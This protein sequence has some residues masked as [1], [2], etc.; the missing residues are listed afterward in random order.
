M[1]AVEFEQLTDSDPTPSF[2]VTDAGAIV[3]INA[4]ARRLVTAPPGTNLTTLVRQPAAEVLAFIQRCSTSRDALPGILH[5]RA[6]NGD[7]EFRCS[8]ASARPAAA[9]EPALIVLR[10]AEGAQANLANNEIGNREEAERHLSL[11]LTAARM[12]TWIWERSAD[13]LTLSE[14]AAE[15]FGVVNSPELGWGAVE[16]TI[17]RVQSRRIRAAVRSTLPTGG[18][19]AVHAPISRP[20][21]AKVWVD[22]R[23]HAHIGPDGQ[24]QRT[25]G[26]VIDM[27]DRKRTE[28]QLRLLAAEVDHRAKNVLAT[29][30]AIV[31]MTRADNIGD[32]VDAITGRI[33]S[34]ANTH[35]LIASSGWIGADLRDLVL[36]ELAPYVGG[37]PS[38]IRVS[39]P[40]VT[41]APASAQGFAMALHELATNA[42]KHGSLSNPS[43]RLEVE[44]T[45]VDGLLTLLWTET[46]GPP[47]VAPVHQGFGNRLIQ[48]AVRQQLGGSVQQDWH[49]LGLRCE[50]RGTIGTTAPKGTPH[51][52]EPHREEP[53]NGTG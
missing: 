33:F 8:A 48:G 14:R 5:L 36:H 23:G 51:Q 27:T 11:A 13:N 9:S 47:V 50:L 10:L 28:D 6:R 49:P 4:A 20:D 29:V 22:I 25:A 30:Q 17:G 1:P 12:G 53:R 46:G 24:V 38:R 45:E 31:R 26:V 42:A 34:L 43:G 37:V 7:M 41:L 32:F 40:S 15:I 35:T 19:F 21:G 44:W 52:A 3:G 2:L 18:Y 39:G 16:A